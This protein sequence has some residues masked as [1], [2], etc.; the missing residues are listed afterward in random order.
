MPLPTANPDLIAF[1]HLLIAIE[2]VGLALVMRRTGLRPFI[3]AVMAFLVSGAFLM[4]AVRVARGG[5]NWLP[6]EA[7]LLGA[8]LAHLAC[9]WLAWRA[10]HSQ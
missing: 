5:M 8:L 4:E 6:V 1:I 3:P 7:L 9:L 2:A 10:L